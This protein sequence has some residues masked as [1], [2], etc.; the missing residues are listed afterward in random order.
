[1]PRPSSRTRIL[2]GARLAVAV[3]IAAVTLSAAT[4]CTS[5]GRADEV[6]SSASTRAPEQSGGQPSGLGQS[7]V[8]P[9]AAGSGSA[10]GD[11]GEPAA[12]QAS[13]HPGKE[14]LPGVSGPAVI[15]VPA[16]GLGA[17][18]APEGPTLTGPLPA[19]GAA[20]GRLVAGFPQ[21]VV[22]V[23]DGVQ[24][25]SSSV[26]SSG[27]RLQITLDGSSTAS[28][29]AVQAAY[30]KELGKSGFAAA[31]SPALPG[32]TAT[33]FTHGTDGLVLT[34]RQR[35]GGGTELTLAGTLTTE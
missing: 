30:V 2:S 22:P 16:G 8:S 10:G 17:A 24:V 35:I 23:V 12:A 6:R 32:Q 25:V 13:A 33:A 15:G 14:Q 20:N 26:S 29:T 11:T 3:V 31:T 28:P 4:G 7:A 19:S 34:V 27:K 18:A 21:H 5:G 9:S 1:M